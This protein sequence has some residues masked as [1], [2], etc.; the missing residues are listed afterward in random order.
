VKKYIVFIFSLV[1]LFSL[2]AIAQVASPTPAPS[3]AAAAAST[4]VVAGLI[5]SK[6][7]LLAFGLLL[8]T[9]FNLFMSSLRSILYAWDGVPAGGAIPPQYTGLTKVN[10]VCVW[11]GKIVDWA[12]ANTQH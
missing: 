1:G 8:V 7:G 12:T 3:P 2:A 4:G 10:V 5:A 11:L 9:C 6:G